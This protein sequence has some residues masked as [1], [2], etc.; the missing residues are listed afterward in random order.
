M[1]LQRVAAAALQHLAVLAE[2]VAEV[3]VDRTRRRDQPAGHLGDFEHH[4][5]VLRLRR[6]DDVQQ[7]RGA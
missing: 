1:N 3:D 2:H 5:Q 7:Q 6:A 4:L